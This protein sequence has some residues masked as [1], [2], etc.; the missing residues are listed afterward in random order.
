MARAAG[1][2]WHAAHRVRGVLGI[3]M[4]KLLLGAG[5]DCRKASVRIRH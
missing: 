2:S 5:R 4:L 3:F 1:T